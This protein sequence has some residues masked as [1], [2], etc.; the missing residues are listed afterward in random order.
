M[1][2]LEQAQVLLFRDLHSWTKLWWLFVRLLGVV[3][4]SIDARVLLFVILPNIVVGVFYGGSSRLLEQFGSPRSVGCCEHFL[5][6]WWV[7][8]LLGLYFFYFYF[9]IFSLLSF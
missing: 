7:F 6:M 1:P 3:K 2:L 4:Q 8:R 5:G 9:H